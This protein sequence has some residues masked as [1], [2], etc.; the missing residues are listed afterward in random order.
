MPLYCPAIPSLPRAVSCRWVSFP[1][2]RPGVAAGAT[3][4]SA[5]LDYLRQQQEQGPD[6]RMQQ[7]RSL[8]ASRYADVPKPGTDGMTELAINNWK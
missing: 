3:R 4:D 7:P 5:T 2:W 6:V 1:A 8:E